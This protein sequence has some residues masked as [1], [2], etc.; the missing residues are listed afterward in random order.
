MWC[1]NPN[2]GNTNFANVIVVLLT[3]PTV[4]PHQ[5][6]SFYIKFYDWIL[7]FF[8]FQFLKVWTHC[9]GICCRYKKIVRNRM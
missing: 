6:R 1:Y 4:I 5:S 8:Q 7:A 2:Y 9:K 3:N